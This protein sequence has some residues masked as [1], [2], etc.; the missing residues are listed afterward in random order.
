MILL[1]GFQSEGALG[2]SG[3]DLFT[4]LLCSINLIST[5]PVDLFLSFLISRI[6]RAEESSFSVARCFSNLFMHFRL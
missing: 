6:F 4:V 2:S 3:M 5:R 1:P